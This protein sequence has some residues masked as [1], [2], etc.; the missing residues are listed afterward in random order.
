MKADDAKAYRIFVGLV[1]ASLMGVAIA[2][3]FFVAPIPRWGV[4]VLGL[5]AITG[6]AY[7]WLAVQGSN[8]A[9]GKYAG[10]TFG[11][12]ALFVIAI[13][14]LAIS[15]IVDR[16]RKVGPDQSPK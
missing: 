13:I 9:I 4:I 12:P 7:C 1:G 10:G 11:H 8:R 15:A 6:I 5:F 3:L 16:F 14:A 2:P